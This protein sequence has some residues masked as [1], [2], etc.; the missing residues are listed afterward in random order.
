MCK[1]TKI[2]DVHVFHRVLAMDVHKNMTPIILDSNY[3]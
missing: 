1:C 2:Y 3:Y